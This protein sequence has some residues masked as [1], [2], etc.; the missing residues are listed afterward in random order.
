MDGAQGCQKIWETLLNMKL[1][2]KRTGELIFNKYWNLQYSVCIRYFK[3]HSWFEFNQFTIFSIL[4]I[5][6]IC[7]LFPISFQMQWLPFT[8][9][10]YFFLSFRP[11][12]HTV[13]RQVD[14]QGLRMCIKQM[15]LKMTYSKVSLWQRRWK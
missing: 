10:N 8:I 5:A 7:D 13:K 11:W 3:V 2:V 4:C 12:R 6:I 15:S 9:P 14:I 1:I